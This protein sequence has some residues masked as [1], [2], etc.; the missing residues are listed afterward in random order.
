[1]PINPAEMFNIFYMHI[2]LI[3]GVLC[4]AFLRATSQGQ[5]ISDCIVKQAYY[6]GVFQMLHVV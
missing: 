6:V 3:N 5:T 4:S 2:Y 1:M